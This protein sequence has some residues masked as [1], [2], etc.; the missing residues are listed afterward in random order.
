GPRAGHPLDGPAELRLVGGDR[1]GAVQPGPGAGE[2][3]A[4]PPDRVLAGQAGHDLPPLVVAPPS[5]VEAFFRA[6]SSRACW[7]TRRSRSAMRAASAERRSS[8]WKTAGRRSRRVAFQRANRLGMIWCLRHTSAWEAAPVRT[9]R[10]T[11]ALNSGVKARRDRRAMEVAPKGPGFIIPV[12]SLQG[13]TSRTR[14][15]QVR[16]SEVGPYPSRH[17]LFW[18]AKMRLRI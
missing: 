13:R 14:S 10:T 16:T 3:A 9:S 4:E 8:A 12:V 18:N 5:H 11:F 1:R 15:A 6:A 7:P 2:Q 17:W